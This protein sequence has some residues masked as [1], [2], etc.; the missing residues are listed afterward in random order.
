MTI[1]A[2]SKSTAAYE[3]RVGRNLQKWMGRWRIFD[4]SKGGSAPAKVRNTFLGPILNLM[5]SPRLW[6][7]GVGVGDERKKTRTEWEKKILP[8][9]LEA[10][11]NALS[12]DLAIIKKKTVVSYKAVSRVKSHGFHIEDI[13]AVVQAFRSSS[14]SLELGKVVSH[15]LASIM[16][17]DD[18]RDA[19]IDF[20][21]GMGLMCLGDLDSPPGF[22][23]LPS[24]ENLQN[25]TYLAQ[26]KEDHKTAFRYSG[27]GYTAPDPT[28]NPK[29]G[30]IWF[31]EAI[32]VHFGSSP[33]SGAFNRA[34]EFIFQFCDVMMLPSSTFLSIFGAMNKPVYNDY[35]T[36]LG[37]IVSQI[38]ALPVPTSDKEDF[39]PPLGLLR[40]LVDPTEELM[41]EIKKK[42]GTNRRA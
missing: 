5:W 41:E 10:V 29:F 14:Y 30:Q 8:A 19:M 21:F 40:F 25:T 24:A 34:H 6:D 27:Q 37:K 22:G 35:L 1:E 15:V 13:G 20:V 16:E 32:F 18:G 7:H 36:T 42:A 26:A 4:A 3:K 23:G 31:I 9:Q 38:T 28:L 12:S 39:L 11:K 2:I 17:G 33:L